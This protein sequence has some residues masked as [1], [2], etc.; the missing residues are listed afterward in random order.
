MIDDARKRELSKRMRT[1]VDQLR[2]RADRGAKDHGQ[3][4]AQGVRFAANKLDAALR[5]PAESPRPERKPTE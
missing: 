2:V 3:P 4:W 1:L 5:E